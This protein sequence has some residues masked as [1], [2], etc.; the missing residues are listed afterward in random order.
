M[1]LTSDAASSKYIYHIK[2]F[3]SMNLS[4]V[5][6][7]LSDSITLVG[8]SLKFVRSDSSSREKTTQD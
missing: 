4:D 5:K 7:G 8:M 2:K 1:P 3:V 6:T